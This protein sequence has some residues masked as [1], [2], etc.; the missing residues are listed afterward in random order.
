MS[1]IPGFAIANA[2]DSGIYVGDI[3]INGM[4]DVFTSKNY[5]WL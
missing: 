2:V 5:M 3:N 4:G 1:F